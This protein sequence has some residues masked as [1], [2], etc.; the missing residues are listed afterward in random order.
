MSKASEKDVQYFLQERVNKLRNKINTIES[1]IGSLSETAEDAK[2]KLKGKEKKLVKNA[3]E[4]LKKELKKSSKAIK[5][6]IEESTPG[7]EETV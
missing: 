7:P 2:V 5:K 3:K 4:K 1:V 6:E